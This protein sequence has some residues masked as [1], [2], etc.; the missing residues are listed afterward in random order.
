[1]P[2]RRL[3]TIAVATLLSLTLFGCDPVTT[4]SQNGSSSKATSK[5]KIKTSSGNNTSSKSH[6]TVKITADNEVCWSGQIGHDPQK[7]CGRAT[8][9]I[10]DSNGNFV[11]QL[12]KT[13]GSGNLVVVLIVDGNTVDSG[14][15]TSNS[16]VVSISF[17]SN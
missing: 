4:T 12:R 1:M 10:R 7:G 15:V 3:T 11:I 16:G 9:F 5:S 13:G 6:A 17:A 8:I 2:V 14:Q